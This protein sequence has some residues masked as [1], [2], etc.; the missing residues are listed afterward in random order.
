MNTEE[1]MDISLKMSGLK[2][3]PCDSEIIVRGDNINSILFGVDAT[4]SEL[5]MAKQLSIDCVISHHPVGISSILNFSGILNAQIE[6]MVKAGVPI[7]KACKLLKDKINKINFENAAINFSRNASSAKLLNIPY[8][9]IHTPADIIS[10]K[11]V[12]KHLDMKFKYN[13]K[14][15]LYEIIESLL[16]IDEYNRSPLKPSIRV[17]SKDDFAGRI[18]VLM[19]GGTIASGE[20]LKAYFDAGI[21]TIICMYLP[22]DIRM[23][24]EEQNIGNIIEAGHMASDS[25][26]INRIIDKLEE[27]G[28]KVVKT[29]GII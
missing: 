27:G 15:R 2:K 11:I 4:I 12:Q 22:D 21:G 24:V 13:S 19:A 7:N 8:I 5:L 3:I 17:G 23:E 18:L 10:E 9:N 1:I 6:C 29:S 16:E 26:G 14:V 25:I 20:V 28:V